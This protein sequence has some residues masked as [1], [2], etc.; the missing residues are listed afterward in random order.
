LETWWFVAV[1]RGG[2][3]M[4]LRIFEDGVVLVLYPGGRM[5]G[6]FQLD[7]DFQLRTDRLL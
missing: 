2:P 4:L 6:I 7:R 5:C 1:R 3:Q